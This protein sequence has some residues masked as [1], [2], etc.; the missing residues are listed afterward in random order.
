M[1]FQNGAHSTRGR[2]L[3]WVLKHLGVECPGKLKDIRCFDFGLLKYLANQ[4]LGFQGIKEA[5]K[6]WTLETEIGSM[7]SELGF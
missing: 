7:W 3:I 4:W 2:D 5:F 1:V 6:E